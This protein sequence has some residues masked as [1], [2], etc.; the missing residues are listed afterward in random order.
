MPRTKI[1]TEM[2]MNSSGNAK[3]AAGIASDVAGK[4]GSVRGRTDSK[5]LGRHGISGDLRSAQRH[6]AQI[7]EEIMAI[8][9]AAEMGARQYQSTEDRLIHM[10]KYIENITSVRQD[11]GI[12]GSNR[13]N[14]DCNVR[15]EKLSDGLTV[16]EEMSGSVGNASA[17]ASV[18]KVDGK[19]VASAEAAASVAKGNMSVDMLNGLYVASGSGSVLGAGA[20]ASAGADMSEGNLEV[21]AKAEA[22]AHA[23]KGE[24]EQER[25]W[26]LDKFKAT[27]EVLSADVEGKAYASLQHNGIWMPGAGVEAEATAAVAKG[28][29]EETIGV[30]KYNIKGGAEGYVLGAEAEAE[31][32]VGVIQEDG[33]VSYGVSA[34]AEAGAYLAKGEVTGGFTLFGIEIEGTLG[35]NVGV[36]VEA[37][38]AVTTDSLN[39]SAGLSAFLGV[40]V[41]L[42][43]DWSNFGF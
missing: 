9:R 43:I 30:E 28:E 11:T 17:N 26:G 2:V 25:L 21:Y 39:I 23:L 14:V 38:G 5:I 13:V 42:E 8:Y 35:G 24:F 12:Q 18:E 27:G 4:V 36:G 16:K 34:S 10:G 32:K 7:S 15:S 40:N 41:E 20:M 1:N 31:A 22:S 29:V 37:G 33:E 19:V 6:V 3:S